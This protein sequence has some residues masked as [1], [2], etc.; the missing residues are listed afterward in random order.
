MTT[1]P[2][3]KSAAKPAETAK[4][5]EVST[6][7]QAAAP[8]PAETAAPKVATFPQVP[9]ADLLKPLN[10]VQ[11]QVRANA[12]KGIERLRAQYATLKG[13]AEQ[14]TDRLEES[15]A[16]AHAG[17]RAFNMKVLE[18]FRQQADASFAHLQALFGVKTLGD[19]VKLQQDFARAQVEL[20]QAHTRQLAEMAKQ[21]ATDVA[22]PVRQSIVQPLGR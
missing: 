9:M 20:V 19:A 5:A 8:A 12:E 4:P 7:V 1:V 11:E 3:K 2:V 15:V 10:A 14:A 22:E 13:S 6:P 18:L 17:S 16:A 21:V